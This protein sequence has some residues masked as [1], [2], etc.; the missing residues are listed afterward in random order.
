M[1][2]TGLQWFLAL[3]LALHAALLVTYA[4]EWLQAGNPGTVFNLTLVDTA[5]APAPA[6][7]TTAAA[8]PAA[9][10]QRS[11]PRPSG[12]APPVPAPA[13]QPDDPPAADDTGAT[14]PAR[15]ASAPAVAGSP[16]PSRAEA[17]RHLRDSV[18][19][20]VAA[21][22]EYPP[23]AR[24]RGWQGVVL[25]ELR[26]ETD[27]RISHTQVSATSGYPVLDAAAVA[28][29][30]LASVPRAQRWLKDGAVDLLVPVEYRLLDQRG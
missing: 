1:R 2:T 9:G 24:R 8:P 17:D 4:P 5:G 3:S 16:E 28:A 27:G 25:L 12:S 19:E 22:L 18:L 20:L 21:N 10:A 29:L 14:A 26:I 15:T 30:Q 23:L 11:S 7:A 13:A 6:P